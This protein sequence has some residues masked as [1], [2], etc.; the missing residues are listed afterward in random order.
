LRDRVFRGKRPIQHHI[1]SSLW[2]SI[3]EEFSVVSDNS[4]WLIGDG[5]YINF[6]SDSWCGKPLVEQLLIP[7]TITPFLTS[8]VSDFLFNGVWDIPPQLLHAYPSLLS[9]ISQVT[10]PIDP[11]SDKLLWMH[12]DDGDLQLKEA[13]VF[14]NQQILELGKS[15]LES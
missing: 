10:I 12:T 15:Y 4:N 13:Y 14:K 8:T 1:F 7:V 11:S 2:C 3:K 5:K 6:W 9:I